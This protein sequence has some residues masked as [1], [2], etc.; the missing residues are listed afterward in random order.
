MRGNGTANGCNIRA[1]LS[2]LFQIFLPLPQLFLQ[3]V[4]A[5]FRV[6]VHL[7]RSLHALLSSQP[8]AAIPN[9]ETKAANERVA[10][11]L[12]MVKAT[13]LPLQCVPILLILVNNGV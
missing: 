10:N 12:F 3:L 6:S 11:L 2:A 7:S 8:T 4:L 9:T 1:S 13:T 5:A